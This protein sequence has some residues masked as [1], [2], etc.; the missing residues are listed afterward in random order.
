MPRQ[1][2]TAPRWRRHVGV[3]G[4]VL[5]VVFSSLILAPQ[6]ANAST[7]CKVRNTAQGS[8]K[9][10]VTYK[11]SSRKFY[12]VFGSGVK[13]T[14]DHASVLHC[15][16][17]Q[18]KTMNYSVSST[19]SAEGGFIF[20]KVSGS[21]TGGL[22][23]SVEAGYSVS[24]DVKVPKGQTLFCD[25]GIYYY[26]F[27]GTVTKKYCTSWCSTTK[28]PFKGKSPSRSIWKLSVGR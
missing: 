21:V 15:T 13:N 4:I 22:S 9:T 5:T 26:T 3:M 24:V 8:I 7:A 23:K 2:P 10:C 11:V 18:K 25:W 27:S 16:S 19:V 14:K 1:F 20:G 6:P 28:T 17:T 12:R